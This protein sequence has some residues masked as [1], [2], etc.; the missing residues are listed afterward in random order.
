MDDLIDV[1][2]AAK[3]LGVS[4]KWIRRHIAEL[5]AIRMGKLIRFNADVLSQHIA[6]NSLKPE[7]KPMLNRYQRG[8]VIQ[9]GKNKIWYGLY[10]ED[11]HTATGMQRY[12]RLI[13]LGTPKE[14]PT[15]NAARNR[16]A[17]LIHIKET[18]LSVADVTFDELVKR[19]EAAEGPAMKE[20]TRTHYMNTL[21][22]YVTPEF[23]GE[24]IADITRE[25]LQL[26]FVSMAKQYA[27]S[28]LRSMRV[29]LSMT[30]GWAVANRSIT[31][32]PCMNIRLPKETGGRRVLR[33][34]LSP[35]QVTVL[36]RKMKEPYATLV[37][38]LYETGLRISEAAALKWADLQ[39]GVLSVSR[40]L[41]N[42]T[43]DSVKSLRAARELPLTPALLTRLENLHSQFP[44]SEWIFQ[45]EAGTPIDPKNALNRYLRPAVTEAGHSIGGWHDFRHTLSTR[46]RRSGTHPKVLSDILGHSKVNLAM[47]V[48]DRTSVEEFKGPLGCY[49]NVINHEANV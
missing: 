42:G 20:S 17:E 31:F 14:L 11:V 7:R 15:K 49:Q 28:T 2:Q 27:Y 46:L 10:R 25:Q 8:T 35:E 12:Q 9:R 18:T 36:I 6:Q 43:V 26:F 32:N 47:D 19:W 1:N 38:L 3:L 16:L 13:R 24:K 41:Y 5:P 45:S 48:Y 21:D 4:G 22:C 34:V 23:K 39:G 33:T 44:N 29:V 37:Q 30:L 40:R